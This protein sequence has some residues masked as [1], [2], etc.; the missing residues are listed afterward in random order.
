MK[1]ELFW[2]QSLQ[3]Y[4]GFHTHLGVQAPWWVAFFLNL[5]RL[6]LIPVITLHPMVGLSPL[7]LLAKPIFPLLLA[8]MIIIIKKK[9]PRSWI[10][11]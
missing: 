2:D 9:I 8:K 7:L 4:T 10:F 3:F 5:G 11:F 6:C 1:E